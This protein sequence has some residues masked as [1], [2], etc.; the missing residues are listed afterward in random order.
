MIGI[1]LM[2]IVVVLL[3]TLG[4][5]LA[6]NYM[7]KIVSKVITSKH[8][9]AE[10]I[11]NTG[12]VPPE[13]VAEVE[14]RYGSVETTVRTDD[15]VRIQE[16]VKTMALKRLTKLM[17]YFEKSPFISDRETRM[18]LKQ[19]LQKAMSDWSAKEWQEIK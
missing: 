16:K 5:K 6:V 8:L 4:V 15:G 7:G 9:A 3:F 11:T 17:E 18:I 13:W 19:E 1:F 10:T 14:K 12:K 2:F